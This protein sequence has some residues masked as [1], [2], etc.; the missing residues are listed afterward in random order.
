MTAF[1][2]TSVRIGDIVTSGKTKTASV[3]GSASQ[4]VAANLDV[5]QVRK[6]RVRDRP[7]VA[8]AH[9]KSVDAAQVR[10]RRVRD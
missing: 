8:A 5:M 4:A 1:D 10:K 3:T 9:V 7:L 2:L 6:R